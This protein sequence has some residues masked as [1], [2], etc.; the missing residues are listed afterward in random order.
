MATNHRWTDSE[1]N[2]QEQTTWFRVAVWGKQAETCNQYLSKGRQVLIEGRLNPDQS[3]N[4]RIWTGSDGVA[5]A[6]YEVTALTVRFLGR[7]EERAPELG[8]EEEFPE[9]EI[10]F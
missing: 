6:S 7:R 4:P 2:R 5:R 8:P 1:G 9:E 3:G 10:P